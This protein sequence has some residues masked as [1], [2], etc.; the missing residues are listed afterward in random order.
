MENVRA[1]AETGWTPDGFR[2]SQGS[3]GHC[4]EALEVVPIRAGS[5]VVVEV[6]TS[7]KVVIGEQ[8]DPMLARPSDFIA[9]LENT[10]PAN[11]AGAPSDPGNH[12]IVPP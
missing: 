12:R 4:D 6:S 5:R 7:E 1:A 11:V 2:Y 3:A 10:E 9:N 8:A